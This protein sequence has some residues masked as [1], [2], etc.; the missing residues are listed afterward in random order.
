MAPK[1]KTPKA[2]AP[3]PQETRPIDKRGEEWQAEKL[4]G[5][6]AQRGT[7]PNGQPRYTYEVK[8]SGKDK[9]GKEWK[10]TYEPGSCLVGWEPEI[11]KIDEKYATMGLLGNARQDQPRCRGAEESPSPPSARALAQTPSPTSSSPGRMWHEPL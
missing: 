4:T 6:R 2:T 7:L 5:A 8:W 1:K 10:N 9:Q 11:K 3:P